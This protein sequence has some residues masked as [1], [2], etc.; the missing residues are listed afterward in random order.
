MLHILNKAWIDILINQAISNP[1]LNFLFV[2][3]GE[4]ERADVLLYIRSHVPADFRGNLSVGTIESVQN[5]KSR[6]EF[7][8]EERFPEFDSILVT[9]KLHNV[10]LKSFLAKH[11]KRKG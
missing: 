3:A 5:E 8:V 10:F 1:Y 2:T 11:C 6:T 7:F 4:R 9:S